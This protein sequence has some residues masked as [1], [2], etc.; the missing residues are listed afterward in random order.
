MFSA[1]F[2]LNWDKTEHDVKL[3]GEFLSWKD[4]GEWHLLERGE[5]IFNERPADLERRFPIECA[6]NPSCW[7][8][9]GL[10]HT[11]ARFSQN[12]GNWIIDIPRPTWAAWVADTWRVNDKLVLNFGL[13]YDLDWG[14]LAPP[15][16][17]IMTPFAGASAGRSAGDSLYKWDIRDTNNIAPRA[18]FAYDVGGTG[19]LVIRGGSGIYH[20]ISSSNVTFS[21]Q[22]FNG[23]RI[24]VNS[25]PN[26]GMPGF[27][28]DPTRGVTPAQILAGE[29]PVPPQAP[30]TIAHNFDL[31]YTWQTS[32][33]FQKQ[34]GSVW[35]FESDLL[36]WK[37]TNTPRATDP[38]QIYDPVTGYN[39][40]GYLDPNFTRIRYIE[41]TGKQDYLAVS[42]GLRRRFRD[43]FQINVTHTFIFYKNDDTR[44]WFDFP[45]NTFDPDAEWASSLDFQVN[46]FRLNGIYQLPYDFAVS[47]AYFYG[48]GHRFDTTIGGRP[49][50]KS[51]SRNRLNLGD[52]IPVNPDVLDRFDGPSTIGT[53]PGNEAPRNA[54]LGEALHKIDVRLSKVFNFGSVRVSA[55]A[56]VFNLLNHENYGR[57]NGTIDSSSF[58]AARQVTSTAYGPRAAQFALRLEY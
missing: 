12:V 48:S 41:S 25:F 19:D 50:G 37:E 56:E 43:N 4:G 40:R 17:D 45:N 2:Q 14:A 15:G 1:R 39:I 11:V 42:S 18:G 10:D 31:P 28:Q 8:V 13:R 7:D 16:N 20:T 30:R 55:I 27:L 33:G 5:F 38:N 23:Q 47:G 29:V 58:G 52:P 32:V 35:G 49:Y 21:Q 6:T 24:L 9:S 26:D 51:A 46:T 36:Y 3:G 44:G 53:G 54:L 22:S 57:Y 34:L